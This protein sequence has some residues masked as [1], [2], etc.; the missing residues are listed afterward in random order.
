MLLGY[1]FPY[2][3]FSM[4]RFIV[5]RY[6]KETNLLETVAFKKHLTFTR[7]LPN[8]NSSV[9]YAGHL[10]MC[11]WGWKLYGNKKVFR[12][13]K[14]PVYVTQHF[15]QNEIQRVK[16]F[17]ISGLIL[18]LHGIAFCFFGYVWPDAFC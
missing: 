16:R 4:Q 6:E 14:D 13:I 9:M 1:I 15:S 17:G 18:V 8:F 3:I 10:M 2:T 11:R 7:Y 5:K 12:D